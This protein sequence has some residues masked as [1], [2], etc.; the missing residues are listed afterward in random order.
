MTVKKR[1]GFVRVPRE[2]LNDPQLKGKHL[3][4]LVRL[5][6]HSDNWVVKRPIEAAALG[7]GDDAYGKTLNHLENC[8]YITRT[9]AYKNGKIDGLYITVHWSM[10]S[11]PTNTIEGIF[12]TSNSEFD[13][14][15]DDGD[16]DGLVTLTPEKEGLENRPKPLKTSVGKRGLLKESK[17]KES[18]R[19]L[20]NSDV[21]HFPPERICLEDVA[22]PFDDP[23]YLQ[24]QERDAQLERDADRERDDHSPAS[25]VVALHARQQAGS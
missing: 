1:E 13:D 16:T 20:E 15:I 2:I 3:A 4:A 10:V 12:N 21:A 25:N 14:L 8:G 17:L 24:S 7:V 22:A 6:S 11:K 5:A 18:K 19:A 23:C 9:K